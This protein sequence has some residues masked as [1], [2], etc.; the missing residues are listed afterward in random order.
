MSKLEV[1]IRQ[2]QKSRTAAKIT[3]AVSL[4]DRAVKKRVIHKNK[5]ARMKSQLAKLM[6][7]K[8]K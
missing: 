4:A 7:P 3:L 5:A 6:T 2:A 8:K 1:A